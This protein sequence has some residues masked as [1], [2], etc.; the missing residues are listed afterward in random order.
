MSYRPKEL[1]PIPYKIVIGIVSVM[2]TTSSDSELEAAEEEQDHTYQFR[3]ESFFHFQCGKVV[4]NYP[5]I[6]HC[7]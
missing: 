6:I 1:F 2:E 4:T 7:A 5:S 3:G